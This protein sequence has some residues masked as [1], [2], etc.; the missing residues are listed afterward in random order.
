MTDRNIELSSREARE[1]IQKE[2]AELRE[3]LTEVNATKDLPALLPLLEKLRELLNEH[4]ATEDG[5]DGLHKAI[6]RS[7]PR[8]MQSLQEIS[9]EHRVFLVDLDRMIALAR[10]CIN[11][12]IA[13]ILKGISDLSQ[14]LHDHEVRETELLVDATYTDIGGGS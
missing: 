3:L 7:E 4:F 13:Q 14:K 10:T 6:A 9:D 5:P 11:G 1:A 12:P 8:F 2:H